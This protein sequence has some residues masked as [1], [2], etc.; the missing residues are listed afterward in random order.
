MQSGAGGLATVPATGEQMPLLGQEPDQS[1]LTGSGE[2]RNEEKYY[3][4]REYNTR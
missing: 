1:L 3:T 4:A 2:I